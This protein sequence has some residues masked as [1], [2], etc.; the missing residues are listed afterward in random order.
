MPVEVILP[1]VDMDMATGQ[2][3]RWFVEEGAEVKKGDVLFEIE[4]DKA[5]MEIDAPASG[6]IRD[7]TGREG[8]DIPVGEAVAWIY[9]AG[10]D[11][12]A[13]A[14]G[15]GET[16]TKAG[17]T[18]AEAPTSRLWGGPAEG[19]GEGNGSALVEGT[20]TPLRANPPYKGEGKARAT[21][22]ARRLAKEAGIDIASVTGS[23][24]YGRVVR[25]D[26]ET[27]I[28]APPSGL[29]AISPSR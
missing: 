17:A 27:A 13:A 22:L 1:K 12:G 8:V 23:G 18:K 3:S 6:T 24:P 25:A 10:E 4:T 29:P 5:A 16:V 19:V 7:I 15:G 11:D 14:K 26:V 2:I 21:P 28:K 9:E 20:P